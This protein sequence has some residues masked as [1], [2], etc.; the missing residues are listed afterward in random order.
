MKRFALILLVTACTDPDSAPDQGQTGADAGGDA[1]T[2]EAQTLCGAPLPAVAPPSIR[3]SG[4]VERVDASGPTSPNG[5]SVDLWRRGGTEPLAMVQTFGSFDLP[6]N[7]QSAP[8]D[9]YLH[10]AESYRSDLYYFFD[11]PLAQSYAFEY[12]L[13][14]V[15]PHLYAALGPEQPDTGVIMVAMHDDCDGT[16]K[17]VTGAT[18]SLSPA[19]SA[20]ILYT[21]L[22]S[23]TPT[24]ETAPDSSTA[25]AIIMNA[26]PGPITITAT[27]GSRPLRSG[28]VL[29]FANSLTVVDLYPQ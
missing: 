23:A 29:A 24:F 21:S 20:T 27:N 13:P 9:V 19:G 18:I 16:D 1:P 12:A 5:I 10:A 17:P 4:D 6:A 14:L 7:T 11:H 25:G 8:I 2:I 22:A 15:K 28:H 3:L 26:P